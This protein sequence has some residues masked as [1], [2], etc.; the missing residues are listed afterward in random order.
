MCYTAKLHVNP[1][2][3]PL[4]GSQELRVDT[5]NIVPIAVLC[6]PGSY[7]T[8]EMTCLP[9]TYYVSTVQVFQRFL[10]PMTPGFSMHG[11]DNKA[12]SLKDNRKRN[13]EKMVNG[14][15]GMTEQMQER[16]GHNKMT[17]VDSTY[18]FLNC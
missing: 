7:P 9:S 6:P 3:W 18:V 8:L 15:R 12:V 10:T 11:A 13:R 14:Y 2:V 4:C 17:K 1:Q 16:L 5:L